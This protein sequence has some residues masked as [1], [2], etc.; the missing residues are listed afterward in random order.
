V[1]DN[2]NDHFLEIN[3]VSLTRQESNELIGNLLH[4]VNLPEEINRLVIDRAAGNP[5][6]IE[7]VIRSFLDEGLIEVKDNKFLLTES[8]RY[9]NIPESI[10]N[11]LLSRIDRLDDKTK[12]LLK[13]ASVIGRNFYYKVLEEA[14]V[15]IEEVDH[16]LEF[17]MDVQLIN[18]RKKKDEVEFLFKHALAQQ[19][20]YESI[21]EKTRKE[22]HLK[23]AA[24]IE[25]VFAG[26]IHEFYGMLAH[27]YS[28]AGQMY[29]AEEY[30]IKA[31]DES[32][33]SGA[34]SEAV[35]FYKVGLATYLQNNK[36]TPE[37]QKVADLEEKLAFVHYA[38]GHFAEAV[39][40]FDK[41]IA[42][43]YRPLSK[44]GIPLLI[45]F[46][47]N[48]L[49]VYKIIYFY[50]KPGNKTDSIEHKLL[51]LVN[52]KGAALT[53]IDPKKMFFES[54]TCARFHKKD[55][56]GSHSASIL[57]V[58]AAMLLYA[59]KFVR[60]GKKVA[61]FTIRFI[62]ENTPSE[63]LRKAYCLS[64]YHYY[65]GKEIEKPDEE[66]V[67]RLALMT[68]DLFAVSSYYVY[69]VY[70]AI[71][72]GNQIVVSHLLNH[73][74]TISEAFD[75]AYP[76]IQFH[77]GNI[78]FHLK[79]RKMDKIIAVTEQALHFAGKNQYKLQLFLCYCHKSMVFSI[80]SDH[81]KS[82]EFLDQAGK[83]LKDFNIPFCWCQYLLAKSY[84]EITQLKS[85]EV[86]RNLGKIALRTTKQL[87]YKS[88]KSPKNLP[89]AY[90]L[91]ALI[92]C[93]LG[94]P[95]QALK[96]FE[97]SIKA[98]SSFNCTL[99]LSRTYFETGRFL[100]D[101]KNKKQ[102]INGMNATECLM[103]ARSM[104]EEMELEWDLKEY[105]KYTG[106]LPTR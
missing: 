106:N 100:R 87:I 58:S 97:R 69:T 64:I 76:E 77:R 60:L 65:I 71:E 56:F 95:H 26:R 53:A 68:A 45:D 13:T 86:D 16:K 14:A 55:V 18:E 29:K 2:L 57:L 39:E 44:S 10:D 43:Y 50:K 80:L 25:K 73:L 5:F 4:M 9:A 72:S 54:W 74:K 79:Y 41:V 103:K 28:K 66:K 7:E 3:V 83:L 15:T 48:L 20:T 89:E 101:P 47:Y 61:K 52:P 59:G 11:V 92:Y 63:W 34:S 104:F 27:H 8:I 1:A 62:D 98:G 93:L 30:L 35:N 78:A 49:I 17:L 105:D 75:N 40:Y 81:E 32:M 94:R 19:A 46:I 6:F 82:R 88:R 99:E 36:N 91:H 51:T 33:R 37:P 96:N 84:L 38:S 21:I 42:F 102:R 24:S 23:I 67:Y 22:L 70:N 31:A 85:E 12:E 90:R